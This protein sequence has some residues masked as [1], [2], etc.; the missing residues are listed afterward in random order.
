MAKLFVAVVPNSECEDD[1]KRLLKVF[2]ECESNV[3]ELPEE[4]DCNYYEINCS[5]HPYLAEFLCEALASG[6]YTKMGP[7]IAHSPLMKS[8][9]GYYRACVKD[10]DYTL[11]QFINTED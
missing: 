11:E 5:E 3:K 10:D 1:V 8:V 2:S 6:K 7:L 4:R 9:Y